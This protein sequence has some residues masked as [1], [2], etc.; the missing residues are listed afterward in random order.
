MTS[1]RLTSSLITR[2]HCTFAGLAGAHAR[3]TH[4]I[5]GSNTP[6]TITLD[7]RQ[8]LRASE[9]F[10]INLRIIR[11]VVLEYLDK[12]VLKEVGQMLCGNADGMGSLYAC[13]QVTKNDCENL[14]EIDIIIRRFG[15]NFTLCRGE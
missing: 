9:H 5:E 14:E 1:A 4:E 8:S 15:Q 2:S 12:R 3:V 11:R 7:R 6:I 10:S 13:R